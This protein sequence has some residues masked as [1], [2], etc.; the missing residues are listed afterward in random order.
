M[1]AK[2]LNVMWMDARGQPR[3]M[4]DK[5]FDNDEA[6][7]KHF[8]DFIC[9]HSEVGETTDAATQVHTTWVTTGE[10]CGV[11]SFALPNTPPFAILTLAFSAHSAGDARTIIVA[12][13][14]FGSKLPAQGVLAVMKGPRPLALVILRDVSVYNDR[15]HMSVIHN[16]I[17]AYYGSERGESKFQKTLAAT[18]AVS[19]NEF[20]HHLQ[21]TP[22]ENEFALSLSEQLHKVI[23]QKYL[24][25]KDSKNL[26]PRAV[27]AVGAIL[28]VDC[29]ALEAAI[30]HRE[31]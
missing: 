20:R 15:A 18:S 16:F 11:A 31:G 25:E 23:E 14:L 8:F 28:L 13:G 19:V 7:T 26:R 10:G 6:L 29:Q 9:I 24:A 27:K 17:G 12:A 5:N 1:E 4:K 22:E 30:I 21:L 3:P 2:P